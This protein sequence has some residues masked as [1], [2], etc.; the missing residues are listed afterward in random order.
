M[1]LKHLIVP[2]NDD[3]S[4]DQRYQS[5]ANQICTLAGE[6]CLEKLEEF[7]E[8]TS[9]LES[10]H[11][12]PALHLVRKSFEINVDEYQRKR[13]TKALTVALKELGF[14]SSKVSKIINAGR[15]LQT[16]NWLEEGR[17]YFG[18][19]SEMTGQEF[20]DKLSEYFGGFGP[21][22]LDVL[23]RMTMHG[24][25][26]AYR[27]FAKGGI[28][29]SQKALEALQREYPINRNERRG[30]KSLHHADPTQALVTHQSLAVIEDADEHPPITQ[31]ES[32][33]RCIDSFFQLFTSGE[34]E[35]R[36][37][38]YTPAAQAHLIDEIKTGITLLEVFVSK[39]KTIENS[40]AH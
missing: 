36:L 9:K 13:I 23:S 2:K 7:Y 12:G 18:S 4:V 24:R 39:N 21:G 40:A 26:K 27:H 1:K 20:I 28:R 32:A 14:K 38:E 34:M 31:S 33:Q 19:K 11:V 15:F 6:K 16:Y 30:R 17:C 37:A 3:G 22:S 35:Q 29:M 5:I 25:K 8:K 10:E